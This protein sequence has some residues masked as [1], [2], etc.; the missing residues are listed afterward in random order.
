MSK[1]LIVVASAKCA[2]DDMEAALDIAPS[3]E[4]MAVNDIGMHIPNSIKHW[5]SNDVKMLVNWYNARRPTYNRDIFLHSNFDGR[6]GVRHWPDMVAGNSSV[7]AVCVGLEL[8]YDRV[9]LCGAPLDDTGHYFDP[10]WIKTSYNNDCEFDEWRRRSVLF[11]GRVFSMSGKTREI[12]NA[13][14]S[15]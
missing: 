11:A 8:G 3:A 14:V 12:L 2:W 5:Y 4:I 15:N 9:Y 1:T 10:H 7:N 6:E 13:V